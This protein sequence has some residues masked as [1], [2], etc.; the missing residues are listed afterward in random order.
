M[1]RF[2]GFAL[3]IL[4]ISPS[5]TARD[6]RKLS[7]KQNVA[8]SPFPKKATMDSARESSVMKSIPEFDINL[9]WIVP[10]EPSECLAIVEINPP[11][12]D[13]QRIQ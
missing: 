5:A 6:M 11:V 13:I 7:F 8:S 2:L 4:S 12:G 9:S 3:A 10:M 1:K